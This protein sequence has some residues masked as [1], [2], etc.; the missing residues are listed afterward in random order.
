[1]CELE[2][3]Y[4]KPN[5]ASTSNLIILYRKYLILGNFL[6]SCNKSSHK[7]KSYLRY[8]L[9][10]TSLQV[11]LLPTQMIRLSFTIVKIPS[12]LRKWRIMVNHQKSQHIDTTY[13]ISN[14][15][16]SSP[17]SV[18]FLKICTFTEPI[19]LYYCAKWQLSS[20]FL[21]RR[22]KV[23]K[24]ESFTFPSYSPVTSV[25]WSNLSENMGNYSN[26]FTTTIVQNSCFLAQFLKENQTDESISG[27]EWKSKNDEKQ[28]KNANY[29]TI[30]CTKSRLTLVLLILQPALFF[31]SLI[32]DGSSSYLVRKAPWQGR[33]REKLLAWL[34]LVELEPLYYL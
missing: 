10:P 25:P 26:S 2:Q 6:E 3:I 16:I 30:F 11:S 17:V 9:F 24:F 33:F 27:D 5:I 34:I 18:N 28:I 8:L 22:Y 20:C 32:W 13:H 29:F 12:W 23:I 15:W 19:Y 4:C 14:C 21:L 1:M 7:K 31:C